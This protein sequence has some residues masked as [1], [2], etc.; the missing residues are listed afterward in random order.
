MRLYGKYMREDREMVSR[1][2]FSMGTREGRLL[3]DDKFYQESLEKT[4]QKVSAHYS[5]EG[6]V[7]E[8]CRIYGIEEEELRLPLKRHHI[9]E[10]RAV[11][12]F[13]VLGSEHLK[14]VD[15]AKYLNRDISGLSQGVRR[16]GQRMFKDEVLRGRLKEVQEELN[17]RETQRSQA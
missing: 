8:V 7:E 12:A 17:R 10:A 11:S 5:L 9:A 4:D 6:V 1:P 14:L 13:I 15:L 16:L 3:G 2:E